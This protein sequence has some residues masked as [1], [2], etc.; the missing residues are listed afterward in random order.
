MTAFPCR[1]APRCGLPASSC[2]V[3]VSAM[4]GMLKVQKYIVGF[5]YNKPGFLCIS[6]KGTKIVDVVPPLFQVEYTVPVAAASSCH[7]HTKLGSHQ[8]MNAA[9]DIWRNCPYIGGHL[10]LFF[11]IDFLTHVLSTINRSDCESVI[12][13]FISLAILVQKSRQKINF[14]R[15]NLFVK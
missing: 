8:Q 15:T 2:D 14:Y 11:Q 7:Q 12:Y 3:Q 9:L 6:K 10:A 13:R 5:F 4:H 1:G